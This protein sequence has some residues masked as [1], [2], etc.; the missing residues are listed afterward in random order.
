MG[1][2]VEVVQ[3]TEGNT[4]WHSF[5]QPATL[6]KHHCSYQTL[7]YTPAIVQGGTNHP[8]R[9]CPPVSPCL[10]CWF[11]QDVPRGTATPQ[12][13]ERTLVPSQSLREG[14]EGAG[15]RAVVLN[16]Q[17]RVR[18]T[19]GDRKGMG[20][21]VWSRGRERTV[22]GKGR[23]RIKIGQKLKQ[24]QNGERDRK[25]N[26]AGQGQ[27]QDRVSDGDRGQG[28]G[29][30]VWDNKRTEWEGKKERETEGEEGAR[31]RIALRRGSRGG[32]GLTGGGNGGSEV[33][34]RRYRSSRDKGAAGRRRAPGPTPPHSRRGSA[35]TAVLGSSLELPARGARG[36]GAATPRPGWLR[37]AFGPPGSPRPRR[38]G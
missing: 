20:T 35:G 19:E 30:T 31:G 29:R 28:Q 37:A 7:S 36:A 24:R 22:Q 11:E 23:G 21:R 12:G 33:P 15:G 2:G 13:P 10:R 5:Y 3:L 4:C 17:L 38:T 26:K 9:G 34:D 6:P 27:R 32:L 1:S 18:G 25:S 8:G 16:G 14:V